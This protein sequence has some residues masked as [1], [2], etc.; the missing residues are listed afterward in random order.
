MHTELKVHELL[1][2]L[3]GKDVSMN[4]YLVN[5][6]MQVKVQ[7]KLDSIHGDLSECDRRLLDRQ[8]AVIFSASVGNHGSQCE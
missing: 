6:A 8:V 7:D 4:E 3:Y 5:K 2:T 1:K